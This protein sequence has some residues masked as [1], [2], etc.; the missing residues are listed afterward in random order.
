M[1][2]RGLAMVLAASMLAS[3]SFGGI[4]VQADDD[5]QKV[6]LSFFTWTGAQLT[7]S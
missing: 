7:R 5:V 6:V 2:K 1:K 3:M 4:T